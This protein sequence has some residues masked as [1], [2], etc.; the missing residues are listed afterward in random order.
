MNTNRWL[1]RWRLRRIIALLAIPLSKGAK[2]GVHDFAK[3]MEATEIM[4]RGTSDSE[5]I[6]MVTTR[7]NLTQ[8]ISYMTSLHDSKLS[9]FATARVGLATIMESDESAIGGKKEEV[10]REEWA[11]AQAGQKMRVVDHK[12]RNMKIVR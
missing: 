1:D 11:K 3:T 9:K 2:P 5:Q 6:S 4:T 7:G 12:G 8:F 10:M